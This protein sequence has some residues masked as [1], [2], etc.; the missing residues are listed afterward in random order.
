MV[1]VRFVAKGDVLPLHRWLFAC[2][3]LHSALRRKT[4]TLWP[5]FCISF[6]RISRVVS[7]LFVSAIY[8]APLL[9]QP[10]ARNQGTAANG[11]RFRQPQHSFDY[12]TLRGRSSAVADGEACRTNC[13][14]SVHTG[15][16]VPKVLIWKG[17]IEEIVVDNS[18]G[19]RSLVG[20][21]TICCSVG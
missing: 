20:P 14:D 17:K 21:T 19:C 8:S 18:S 12:R 15:V 10:D 3:L 6:C 9:C 1:C 11:Q 13:G 4:K 7:P 5:K 16:L 2:F